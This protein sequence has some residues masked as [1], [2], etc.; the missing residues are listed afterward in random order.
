MLDVSG[1]NKMK[2]IPLGQDS[3]FVNI[4]KER[5]VNIAF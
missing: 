3:T 2:Q 1:R 5:D 4:R